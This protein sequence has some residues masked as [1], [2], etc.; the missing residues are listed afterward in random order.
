MD[1][2]SALQ[3]LGLELPS[4]AYVFG[5]CLFSFIGI[6]AW[7]RGKKRQDKATRWLGFGLMLYPYVTPQTWLLYAVG[8][9]LCAALFVYGRR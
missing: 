6:W 4:P 9:G 1:N 5:V 8:L 2:L 3:S 7:W